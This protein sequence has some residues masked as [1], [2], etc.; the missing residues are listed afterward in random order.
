MRMNMIAI[1]ERAAEALRE[2]LARK[3]AGPQA[4]LRLAVRRGGCAGWQYEMCIAEPEAGDECH[5]FDGGRLI[6]A[7]D[8]ANLLRGCQVDYSD[9]LSDA[10]FRID[11]P[12]ASRSCGCGTS[13]EAADEPPPEPSEL[14][15]CGKS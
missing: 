7:A 13:F 6:V 15:D 5:E 11:N 3:D 10:G 2:L 14:E 8:S 9:A 4:G 1:T 12:N